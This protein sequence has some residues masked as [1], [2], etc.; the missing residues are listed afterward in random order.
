[1]RVRLRLAVASCALVFAVAACAPERAP[2]A[3]G[4]PRGERQEFLAAPWP[5]DLMIKKDGA[6]NLRAF[7]NSFGSQT[8]EQFLGI[9]A[10]APAYAA[11][12]TLY[13]RVDGGVDEDTLPRTPEE[14]LADGA[15]VF[16]VELDGPRAGRRLPIELS[17][18]DEGTSFLPAGTVAVN[19][20]LGVVPRGRFALVATSTV[21]RKDGTPL[22]P[23]ADL[24]ALLACDALDD[25]DA[26]FDCKD[27]QRVQQELGLAT[28]D[29]ASIQ[30]VTPRASTTGLAQAAAAARAYVPVI[31]PTL[32]RRSVRSA[33]PFFVF[34]GT[35]TLAR[36]QAGTPP[37]ETYDGQS[38][39]FVLDDDGVP[40]VQ[41]EETIPFVLTVPRG[42]AMPANGWPI[43]VN[44]HGT[45]GD[46]HGGVGNRA[47]DE[48]FHI[49]R[50]G[51][52]MLAISEPLHRTREGYREG[53]ENVLTFNFFNPLAGRDNWRQS[54]LEKVQLVN[55]IGSL[56]F[57]DE[58]GAQQRFDPAHVGYF[59]HSQGG[60]VGALFV[61][62]EDRIEGAFLSGAGA[63]FAQ[64]LVEKTD[65]PPAI[66]DVLRLVL[67]AP[68]GEPIDRFHPVPAILQTFVDESDPLN[69]GPLWRHRS[70]R[71]TPHLI[72]TSGL[73]DTFTPPRNHEGLAGSFE[74]PLA[75]PVEQP[76]AVL[77]R[78][79]IDGVGNRWVEGNT[80]TDD[81]EP[82][83][84]ALVQFADQGHFAV[85]YDPAAQNMVTDFFASLWQGT[86]AVRTR[87]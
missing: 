76:L 55:A 20:L 59:G 78:L 79:G 16:V 87:R 2:V 60:I 37:Y 3:F 63:G 4:L 12:S 81:G 69:Y 25:V 65:P 1:M 35:I 46:L 48:A 10:T 66:A 11:A 19:L 49:N 14:S 24:K 62:V 56:A 75:D 6:L 5:S 44:G 15:G 29:V 53:Q 57:V 38:G 21:H 26:T 64:S 33:D 52:A 82:L 84:A 8:L 80:T 41:A 43:V 85:F 30:L 45:G 72:A 39:G 32:T 23:D 74:L 28:D 17:V 67:Q 70:G 36:Y 27:Y 50:G 13:F 61:A 40:I 54:A 31:G 77:D 34:D 42:R 68:D 73:Q 47:G 86:P 22:G 9:F 71:R 18:Y 7:P 83:T 51:A 58:D